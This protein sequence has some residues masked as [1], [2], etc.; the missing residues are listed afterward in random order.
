VQHSALATHMTYRVINKRHD[1]KDRSAESV[2]SWQG[3]WV[4]D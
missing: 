3:Q 1:E 4:T 2:G